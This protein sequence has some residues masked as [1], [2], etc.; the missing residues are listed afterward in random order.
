MSKFE[1][2]RVSAVERLT[3]DSVAVQLHVPPGLEE[4]FRFVPGQY[5]TLKATIDG[6]D[7]RRPYS[8]CSGVDEPALRVGVK[9]VEGGVFSTFAN[10]SLRPD[11]SVE[12]MPPQGNFRWLRDT[13]R[14]LNHLGIAAG[15]GITP[16]LSIA[17]SVLES[18]ESDQFTLL[19]GNRS[20]KEIMFLDELSDLKDRHL[21]RFRVFHFLSREPTELEV[22]HGRLDRAKLLT[23]HEAGILQ[24][25]TLDVAYVCGPGDMIESVT[26]ALTDLGVP[27][28]TIRSERFTSAS[29]T[30]ERRA[31][32]T[33]VPHPS[34]VSGSTV[35]ATVDGV[36]HQFIASRQE[37]MVSAAA[38]QGVDL[39]YSCAGGMCC[40]CRCRVLEGEVEMVTNYSL[41]PWE[42]K[43]GYVL[44]CQSRP[45]TERVV[46]DFDAH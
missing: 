20:Q 25:E 22:L 34:R 27:E 12:V 13:C 21:G 30:E 46:L 2:L 39:P 19:Y 18:G 33:L 9:K 28:A 38:R 36:Q 15:S 32:S 26:G 29:S 37:N 23:L 6:H 45:K 31:R 41:E 1:V 5:L 4:K 43:A 40:T 10:V 11:S 16:I 44:A 14:G 17:R 7:V 24:P 42:L 3:D 8:I 35:R